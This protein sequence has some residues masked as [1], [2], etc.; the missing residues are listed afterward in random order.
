MQSCIREAGT[1]D[2]SCANRDSIDRR[3]VLMNHH[4]FYDISELS[5]S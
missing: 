5:K 1:F 2:K 3:L 4:L